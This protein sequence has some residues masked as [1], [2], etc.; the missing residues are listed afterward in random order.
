MQPLEDEKRNF[1]T[2]SNE[3]PSIGSFCFAKKQDGELDTTVGCQALSSG[4]SHY[5]VYV[6][7]CDSVKHSVL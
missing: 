3:A 2:I 4:C 5:Y 6:F 1:K 7:T